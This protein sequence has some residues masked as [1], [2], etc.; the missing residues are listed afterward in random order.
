MQVSLHFCLTVP[1]EHNC[2]PITNL[3]SQAKNINLNMDGTMTHISALHS[4]IENLL[5][6]STFNTAVL[7][8]QYIASSLAIQTHFTLQSKTQHQLHPDVPRHSSPMIT[9]YRMQHSLNSEVCHL[10]Q[11]QTSKLGKQ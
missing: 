9:C 6:T 10:C 5:E 8:P 1:K 3:N 11:H 4:K 2:I 7:Y